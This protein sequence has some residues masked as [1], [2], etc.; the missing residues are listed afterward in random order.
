MLA[1]KKELLKKA[2]IE[3]RMKE[4][5]DIPA[6]DELEKEHEFSED[7]ELKIKK[8]K[9]PGKKRSVLKKTI[10][11]AAGF[12]IIFTLT[13]SA[14]Y[15][16]QGRD[17]FFA[18]KSSDSLNV[19]LSGISDGGVSEELADSDILNDIPEDEFF[20][21]E[22]NDGEFIPDMGD[23][24]KSY[25]ESIA[26]GITVKV[27]YED[28]EI[29]I[30]VDYSMDGELSGSEVESYMEFVCQYGTES[31]ATGD[32]QA[33]ESSSLPDIPYEFTG[34]KDCLIYKLDSGT[35][36]KISE[37][38]IYVNSEDK[39]IKLRF[40]VNPENGSVELISSGE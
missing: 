32:L 2:L 13:G 8:I 26:G 3:A 5:E 27:S 6:E 20:D 1:E 19:D 29:C 37:V 12:V 21:G 38:H 40:G 16:M 36:K 9:K 17:I 33:Q 15:I 14:L 18:E 30:R 11:F 4:L 23:A 34:E 22:N 31:G 25:E 7:F 24:L 10:S 28:D 35:V 39:S